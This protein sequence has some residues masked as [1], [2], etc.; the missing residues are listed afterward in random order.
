MANKVSTIVGK[1]AAAAGA[2]VTS[3]VLRAVLEEEVNAF[4]QPNLP[5]LGITPDYVEPSGGTQIA[6][7]WSASIL[8]MLALR[9]GDTRTDQRLLDA[10]AEIDACL[11]TLAASAAFGATMERKRWVLF[12]AVDRTHANP[13][14][15]VCAATAIIVKFKGPLLG[16]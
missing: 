7:D 6:P 5:A 10:V 1:I 15:A 9:R 2:L 3:G 8:L 16:A 14:A 4:T 12:G 13:L 11:A